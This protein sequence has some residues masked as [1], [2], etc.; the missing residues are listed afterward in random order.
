[1]GWAKHKSRKCFSLS[2]S[3]S[4][5]VS[6]HI[7]IPSILTHLIPGC[8]GET[9]APAELFPFNNVPGHCQ[10]RDHPAAVNWCLAPLCLSLWCPS[11]SVRVCVCVCVWEYV[12]VCYQ[13]GLSLPTL[14]LALYP[15]LASLGILKIFCQAHSF[16]NNSAE[17]RSSFRV[18][19]ALGA[20]SAANEC[21]PTKNTQ[22]LLN[23]LL[24]HFLVP[25][26]YP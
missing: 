6:T 23:T 25:F 3:L 16:V 13:G 24:C 8:L 7:H 1:M 15:L 22:T 5:S 18:Q 4:L 20:Q 10:V 14:P 2:H 11:K 9:F 12:S 26:N 17:S 19:T 21:Q